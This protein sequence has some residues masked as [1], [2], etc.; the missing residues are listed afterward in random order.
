MTARSITRGVAGFLFGLSVTVFLISVWGR[1]M[2]VDSNTLGQALAPLSRSVVVAERFADWMAEGLHDAGVA[3]EAAEV[4]IDELLATSAVAHALDE[5]V[6][7]IVEAAATV[8]LRPAIV[9]VSAVLEPAVHEITET[10][11]MTGVPVTPQEVEQMVGALDPLVILG[12]GSVPLIGPGSPVAARLGLAAVLALV[13][14]VATGAVAVRY[15]PDRIAEVKSLLMRVSVGSLSFALLL[16][17]G[18]WVLDPVGGRAP[19][20]EALAG[21]A[22][23]KWLTPV[24]V[25]LIAGS[26]AAVLWAARRWFRPEAVLPLSVELPTPGLEPQPSQRG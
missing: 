18:S 15:A 25:A 7:G 22:H 8:D 2:V 11:A 19:V 17:V 23:S 13:S 14:M 20:G 16:R 26:V 21:L 1:A 3:P 12:E 10:L 4:A 24:F 5:L 6:V 9:D